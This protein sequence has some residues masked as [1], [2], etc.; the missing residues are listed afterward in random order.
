MSLI[1][2]EELWK[3]KILGSYRNEFVNVSYWDKWAE[4]YDKNNVLMQN[5][6]K[7]QL[8][9]LQLSS[10]CTVLDVGAGTGRLTIPIANCVKQVTA[11]EP[12]ENMLAFLKSIAE[13]ENVN[14][15]VT[16]N[17]PFEDLLANEDIQP[18]DLV[19]A[20]LSLCMLDLVT[21]LQKMNTLAKKYV[22]LFLPAS[23]WMNQELQKII[24]GNTSPISKLG[25]YIY[26]YNILHDLGI[27]ANVEIWDFAVDQHYNTLDEAVSK[28]VKIFNLYGK[29]EKLR[30]C[31][32]E[33]LVKK[34]GKLL[35]KDTRKLA[36]IS[37]AKTY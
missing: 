27:L 9:C 19:V 35:L 21:V 13:K 29:K 32:N 2:W 6:T 24:H 33:L 31:L 37:W 25:D 15:I 11:V 4:N 7:Y 22:Y 18:H 36:I 16:V 12:S 30:T 20:S 5:L 8:D 14:N 26:V 17:R 3:I 10:G 1:N 23:E 34:N 28:Y